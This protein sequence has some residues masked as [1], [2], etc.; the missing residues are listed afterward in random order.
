MGSYTEF[1]VDPLLAHR[2]TRYLMEL[3]RMQVDWA[4]EERKRAEERVQTCQHLKGEQKNVFSKRQL[5]PS[6]RK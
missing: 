6:E 4:E 2:H 5:E 1:Q 3:S